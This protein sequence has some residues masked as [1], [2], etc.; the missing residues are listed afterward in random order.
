MFILPPKCL[1]KTHALL[2]PPL[3]VPPLVSLV[4]KPIVCKPTHHLRVRVM[5]GDLSLDHYDDS[6]HSRASLG[7]L[8][9]RGIGG[10]RLS[11][12][13]G[14]GGSGMH[15]RVSSGLPR[16]NLSRESSG[17]FARDSLGLSVTGISISAAVPWGSGMGGQNQVDEGGG[18]G[19][20]HFVVPG[21]IWLPTPK[22]QGTSSFSPSSSAG[23]GGGGI[24]GGRTGGGSGPIRKSTVDAG[25]IGEDAADGGFFGGS[26]ELRCA[27]C[28]NTDAVGQAQVRTSTHIVCFS[29]TAGG[30]RAVKIIIKDTYICTT[31]HVARRSKDT[32]FYAC[33]ECFAPLHD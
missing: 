32:F 33:K 31:G 1:F 14:G 13:G 29:S 5:Q 8:G 7:G 27:R 2:L 10:L 9:G 12:G 24:G 22:T 26:D 28:S 15:S 18:A 20:Q 19:G 6:Q 4:C 25:D 23:G 16:E 30:K 3:L 21:G 11:G 17:G